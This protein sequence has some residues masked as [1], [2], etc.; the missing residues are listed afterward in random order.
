MI[1]EKYILCDRY[2]NHPKEDMDFCRHCDLNRKCQI[3][4]EYIQP[5]L[6]VKEDARVVTDRKIIRYNSEVYAA[7]CTRCRHY[8]G[9]S[10]CSAYPIKIPTEI[11]CGYVTHIRP[12]KDDQGIQFE[13]N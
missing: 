6:W 5:G 2:K 13:P 3:Y 4:Q 12:Y 7:I 8:Q 1:E 10:R 9:N 11:L